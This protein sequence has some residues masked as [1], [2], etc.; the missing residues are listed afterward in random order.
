MVE[1][2]VS[3]MDKL[4]KIIA[5][6]RA[7]PAPTARPWV[8]GTG[9]GG[10]GVRSSFPCLLCSPTA[11]QV[12]ESLET[13][14]LSVLSD[15]GIQRI[16]RGILQSSGDGVFLPQ[17]F[18]GDQFAFHQSLPFPWSL[19]FC[20]WKQL[21]DRFFQGQKERIQMG[22]QLVRG[23]EILEWLVTPMPAISARAGSFISS[24]EITG[25]E[26]N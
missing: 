15:D 24:T 3:P 8:N 7:A 18:R 1:T 13:S 11:S 20:Y 22:K 5:C 10:G 25:N 21:V 23:Q 12:S 9:W 17:E 16:A 14:A 6:R 4:K 26:E 19:Y 2:S